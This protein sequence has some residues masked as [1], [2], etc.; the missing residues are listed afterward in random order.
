MGKKIRKLVQGFIYQLKVLL[1][2]LAVGA[3]MIISSPLMLL[4]NDDLES[5]A[6]KFGIAGAKVMIFGYPV[7]LVCLFI[8]LIFKKK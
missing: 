1:M 6:A 5:T 4:L 2:I 3:V 7:Y 8:Q